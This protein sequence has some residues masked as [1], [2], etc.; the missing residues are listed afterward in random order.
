[1]GRTDDCNAAP[2]LETATLE[3]RALE[4]RLVRRQLQ[5]DSRYF[6]GNRKGPLLAGIEAGPEYVLCSQHIDLIRGTILPEI[7]IDEVDAS[8]LNLARK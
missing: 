3:I 6:L 8:P 7:G 2:F 1:M 5:N 4:D